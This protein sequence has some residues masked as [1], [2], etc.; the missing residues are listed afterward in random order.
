MTADVLEWSYL[1]RG[2]QQHRYDLFLSCFWIWRC[3]QLVN[4]PLHPFL[5]HGNNKE[6]VK[7]CQRDK[8]TWIPNPNLI[9]LWSETTARG[10]SGLA[11][12]NYL[13]HQDNCHMLHVEMIVMSKLESYFRCCKGDRFV[14]E[15]SISE[16]ILK[17]TRHLLS[18]T[19]WRCVVSHLWPSNRQGL[20]SCVAY[21][22]T[23][24]TITIK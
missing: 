19:P 17:Q 5:K 11:A 2:V 6:G 22:A 23:G 3:P 12:L 4:D 1:T 15:N 14:G 18:N 13:K 16:I 24:W 7:T 20:L 10:V 21:V 8:N 9:R